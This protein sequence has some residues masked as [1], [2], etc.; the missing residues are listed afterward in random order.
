MQNEMIRGS[1]NPG[2]LAIES[3]EYLLRWS[4]IL[5]D[6]SRGEATYQIYIVLLCQ[7]LMVNSP[8]LILLMVAF[9]ITPSWQHGKPYKY[10]KSMMISLTLVYT[11]I[12]YWFQVCFSNSLVLSLYFI[13]KFVKLVG[14]CLGLF[15]RVFLWIGRVYKDLQC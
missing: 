8:L 10:P 5:T 4:L 11:D 6:L 12:L 1:I 3:E 14:I 2:G 9:D 13:V 7:L 15:F